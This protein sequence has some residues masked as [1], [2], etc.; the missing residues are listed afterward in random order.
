MKI[1]SLLIFVFS[2]VGA[3]IYFVIADWFG[4][5]LF[6]IPFVCAGVFNLIGGVFLSI[7]VSKRDIIFD[8]GIM[9]PQVEG[10]LWGLFAWVFILIYAY[11]IEA[12]LAEDWIVTSP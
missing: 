9:S 3:A 10:A 2:F 7:M 1:H 5:S 12:L 11:K 4:G 8:G 6:A